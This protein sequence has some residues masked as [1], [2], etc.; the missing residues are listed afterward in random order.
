LT[1]F[2]VFTFLR[3]FLNFSFFAGFDVSLVSL[4]Q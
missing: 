1:F 4:D 2:A 3:F